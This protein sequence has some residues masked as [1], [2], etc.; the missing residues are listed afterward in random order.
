MQ[1]YTKHGILSDEMK[2]PNQWTFRKFA[3]VGTGEPFVKTFLELFDYL[4][5]TLIPEP[6]REKARDAMGNVLT[7]GLIPTFLEL[8]ELQKAAGTDLPLV[9]QFQLYEDFSRKLWKSYKDLTQRCADEMGFDIGFLFQKDAKFEDGLAK[10]RSENPKIVPEFE[11]YFRE[12]RRKWQNELSRFRNGFI[13]HQEGERKDFM[14]FYNPAFCTTLFAV[15]WDTIVQI[16]IA[17]MNLKMPPGFWIGENDQKVDPK[18]PNRFRVH[19]DIPFP[20]AT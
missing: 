9:N 7:D 13:E 6:Q 12:I 11:G 16:L 4:D 8:R 18:W 10:F 17:L 19:C 3:D 1:K 20:P 15:V 5:G 14:K 2:E